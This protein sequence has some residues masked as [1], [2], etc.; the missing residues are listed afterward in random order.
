MKHKNLTLGSKAFDAVN[1]AL[2]ILILIAVLYPIFNIIATSLSSARYISSGGVTIWPRG[3]TIE[4]YK[5][6]FRDPYI[7]KG[8]INST[9]YAVGSTGT[10]AT[11]TLV[12]WK[13]CTPTREARKY[14][15]STWP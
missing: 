12:P 15:G 2:M 4:A 1:I 13:A 5:T 14:V 8:Y 9:L 3:F 11:V 10:P 6:V 7:Y